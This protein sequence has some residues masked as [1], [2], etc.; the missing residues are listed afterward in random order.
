LKVGWTKGG[1]G[2]NNNVGAKKEARNVSD[3]TRKTKRA[4]ILAFNKLF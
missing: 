2:I 1:D 4:K 3:G